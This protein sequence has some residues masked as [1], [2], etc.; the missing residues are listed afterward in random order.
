M[1][2]VWAP[3]NVC[4]CGSARTCALSCWLPAR[5]LRDLPV[6][7]VVG[8]LL[9]VWGGHVWLYVCVDP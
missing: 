8:G 3:V 5:V 1:L 2:Y 4:M 7:V 6:C 9:P